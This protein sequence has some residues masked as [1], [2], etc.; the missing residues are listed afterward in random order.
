MSSAWSS[1]EKKKRQHSPTSK[2]YKLV[3]FLALGTIMKLDRV[4]QL[5]HLLWHYLVAAPAAMPMLKP[6]PK[7]CSLR[8]SET[9][10]ESNYIIIIPISPPCYSSHFIST[11]DSL[12]LLFL[13]TFISWPKK[14]SGQKPSGFSKGRDSFIWLNSELLQ[15][16]HLLGR[17]YILFPISRVLQAVW[18]K[19][20]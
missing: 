3:F 16:S 5:F 19:V 10:K 14:I 11:W 2:E 13:K 12:G 7:S 8:R 1:R 17:K 15:C 4:C 20:S 6:S 9:F 18:H